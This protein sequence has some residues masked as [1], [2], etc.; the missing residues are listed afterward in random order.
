MCTGKLLGQLLVLFLSAQTSYTKI[1]DKK[2]LRVVGGQSAS[3]KKYPYVAKLDILTIIGDDAYRVPVCTCSILTPTWTLTSSHCYVN[4]N[5]QP[6][7][8]LMVWYGST[9][10]MVKNEKLSKVLKFIIHP[11]YKLLGDD[12]NVYSLENDIAL[13]KT[14]PI[15]LPKYGR[16]S[17]VDYM[18][19]VGFK[20]V[21]A[22]FGITNYTKLS[23]MFFAHTL[24][25]NM[26]LQTL[27]V[28]IRRCDS[29]AKIYPGLCL[30]SKCRESVGICAGDSGG[31]LIYNS[32]IVGL[33]SMGAEEDCNNLTED[34][35]KPHY[36]GFITAV[37]PF[38][39]WIGKV[40]NENA[41][42]S[43]HPDGE[44]V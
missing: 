25:L 36:V 41:K 12:D 42:V 19:L 8:T 27:N 4:L 3:Y 30:A 34:R 14:D 37:S 32:R 43:A 22:G 9:L 33:S 6:N 20:A 39:E 10:P 35:F 7:A 17:S 11:S 29:D 2:L 13:L 40:I 28:L 21:I 18:S 26:P 15:I 24:E 44:R 38:T 5:G 16:V 23:E 31:P 1:N